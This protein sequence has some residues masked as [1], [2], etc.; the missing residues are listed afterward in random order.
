MNT[1]DDITG[2]YP[3]LKENNPNREYVMVD[4]LFNFA[5]IMHPKLITNQYG[6]VDV[7][8]EVEDCRNAFTKDKTAS[9]LRYTCLTNMSKVALFFCNGVW[10]L[11]K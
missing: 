3:I 1:S 6:R 2:S 11:E 5:G 10:F 9:G 7:V 4:V 8:I